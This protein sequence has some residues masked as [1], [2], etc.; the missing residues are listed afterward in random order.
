MKIRILQYIIRKSI[1]NKVKKFKKLLKQGYTNIV[2]HIQVAKEY[3]NRDNII[4][5][6]TDLGNNIRLYYWKYGLEENQ[7]EIDS[8]NLGDY[9]SYV[10]V[11]HLLS[12][13]KIVN[14]QIKSKTIY[15]IGSIIGF[16]CQNAVVWGSGILHPYKEYKL[17]AKLSLLDIRA[18]RG[19]KTREELI[20]LNKKCPEVYGDPAILMPYVFNPSKVK[21]IYDVTIIFNYYYNNFDIPQDKNIN[22]LDIITTDYQDFITQIVQSKL[23]ISSSLHGIIL[24]ETYGVPAV[25]LIEKYQS[26]FKYEDWYY[27]TGRYN[28]K[29]ADTI[30]EA[31]ELEPMILPDLKE[32]Q[33][34]LIKA[35]PLDIWDN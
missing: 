13:K 15:A 30:Q 1:K 17:K 27:S 21:K 9:L 25:L 7:Q 6:D 5:S 26:K 28:I 32:M 8:E 3:V 23:V 11:K 12:H 29:M 2:L 22:F 10:V 33:Q 4:Q 31:L 35:F 14:Q 20:K 19:P 18:V 34:N 24:A 16:R